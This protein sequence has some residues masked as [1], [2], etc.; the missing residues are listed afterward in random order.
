MSSSGISFGGLASG[1][2]TQAIISALTALERRPIAQLETKK[3]SLNRQK[4]LFGDL[5][6]LLDTLNTKAKALQTATNFLQKK[7]TSSDEDLL[8][9]SASTSATAGTHEITVNSLARARVN[10]SAGFASP[11]TGFGGPASLQLDVGGNTYFVAVTTPTLTSVA[12]A[13]NAQNI[14][15]QAQVVDTGNTANGGTERYQLVLRA[16]TAGAEGAFTVSYDDGDA[17]FQNLITGLEA[18]EIVPGSNE[19]GRAHV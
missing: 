8:R 2:D 4:S 13:I 19:I 9:V 14:G 16:T 11:T 18:N 5:R 10:A 6:G 12:D 17:A 3:T 1:L 15:V 7:A